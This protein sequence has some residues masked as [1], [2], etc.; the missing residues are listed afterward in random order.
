MRQA[1]IILFLGIMYAAGAIGA[2]KAPV[3]SLRL[4]VFDCG[5][6]RIDDVA[7][8][9]LTNAD[10]PVREL[11]V[12]C[13]LIEHPQGRMIWDTGLPMALAGQGRVEMQPGAT[14]IYET[15][16]VDQLARL[17]L[18][19]ADIKYLA[20]SHM[21]FDHA[22]AANAFDASTL[23]I[24]RP[25]FVAAFEHASDYPVFD[26]A[27]YNAL[28][29]TPKTLLDGD[30]DVFGDGSVVILSLPGHTPG[31]QALAV[32]LADTGRIV[33]SGDQYHFRASRTLRSVPAFNDN[34]EATLASMDKLEAYLEANKATLWIEHDQVFWLNAP[35]T[36]IRDNTCQILECHH[37]TKA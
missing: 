19:P 10:T 36:L 3:E 21:H 16:L 5:S 35:D 25:E 2:P 15:S 29:D 4:T 13:Y 27:L 34:L 8:F 26:A 12:P 14:M 24:Q 20:L 11:F 17:D 37:G 6:L 18:V 28:A 1:T 32:N 31:H 33:L 30:H 9:G 7:S 22:G 23:L